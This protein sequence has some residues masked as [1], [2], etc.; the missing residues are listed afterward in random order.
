VSGQS[1]IERGKILFNDPKLGGSTNDKS[2]NSCHPGG[3]G[4]EKADV[5]PDTVNLCIK[6][7][8]AGKPLDNDSQEMKDIIAYIQ[9]LKK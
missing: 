7:P 9:S 2:C 4:L 8:L 1:S 3:K 5:T 6:K